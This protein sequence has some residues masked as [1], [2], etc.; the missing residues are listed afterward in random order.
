MEAIKVI[1]PRA[2][3]SEDMI[4]N[5]I[6]LQGGRLVSQNVINADGSYDNSTPQSVNFTV[7]P[8][9]TT[10]ILDRRVMVK[11]QIKVSLTTTGDTQD[12]FKDTDGLGFNGLRQFPMSSIIDTTTVQINGESI[13]DNT[14]DILHPMLNYGVYYDAQTSYN[15]TSPLMNDNYQ[16]YEDWVGA[17][18]SNGSAKNPL[19]A[20]GANA[21]ID[22]RASFGYK[23]SN[24]RV[25]NVKIWDVVYDITEPLF[26]SPFSSGFSTK[27]EQGFVN[28]NQMTI[29]LR[30]KSDIGYIW[31]TTPYRTAN[32]GTFDPDAVVTKVDVI[33]MATPTLLV[34]YIS[35]DITQ[36]IPP[37]Q[38]LNYSKPLVFKKSLLPFPGGKLT[39]ITNTSDSIKLSQIPRKMFLWCAVDPKDAIGQLTTGPV[40]SGKAPWCTTD[41]FPGLSNVNVQ[42]A[43]QTSLLAT[44]TKEQLYDMCVMNGLKRSYT[45]W[46]DYVGSV[47]CVEFGTQIGLLDS[48]APGCVSQAQIQVTTTWVN[49]QE[50]ANLPQ[51]VYTFY[52]MF[53]LEG[54]CSITENSARALLGNFT[55]ADVLNAKKQPQSMT[56]DYSDYNGGGQFFTNLK[57]FFK[58][59]GGVSHKIL[60]GPIGQGLK[61]AFPEASPFI[62]G[63]DKIA[64]MASG[65]GRRGRLR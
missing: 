23:T 11:Y 50:N 43:N 18:P 40:T 57:N 59:L 25:G 62:M 36:P 33:F 1:D 15:S 20:W 26:L 17:G 42:W 12:P 49:L 31:S 14:A 34:T 45:Q 27:L 60:S 63:A 41:T 5:H 52:M 46:K 61:V 7:N 9:S 39:T 53:L 48:E 32:G 64:Q 21:V 44:A 55:P 24:Q 37:I 2:D 58:K 22:T 51:R 54:T 35:P 19:A 6:I 16:N 10:T 38:V 47:Y 30:F 56:M 3:V 28:I 4:R 8:P 13:S 29:N 65:S